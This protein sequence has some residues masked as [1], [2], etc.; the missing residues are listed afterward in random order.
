MKE[1]TKIILGAAV[2]LGAFVAATYI[3]KSERAE[4]IQSIGPGHGAPFVQKYSPTK[5]PADAKVIIAE[6]FD[7][8]CEACRA[9]DPHVK[10]LLAAHPGKIRLVHRYMPL[11]QGADTMV[12]ILEAARLQG[13]YWETLAVMFDSQPEWASHHHPQPEKIWPYLPAAGVDVAQIRKDMETPRFNQ[14]I[15]QDMA[16]AKLLGARKTPTFFVNGKPLPSFGLKQLNA[17][18]ASEIAAN[19]P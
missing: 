18:V 11:H 8:G 4:K 9:L 13:K 5:G 2:L 17:L 10:K 12:K 14:I 3:Y 15:E 6:F 19:Y 1:K 16:D 7:P